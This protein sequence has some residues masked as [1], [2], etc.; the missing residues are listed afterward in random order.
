MKQY[1]I[2]ITN[3]AL[4]DLEEIYTYIAEQLRAPEAAMDQF[5]RIAEAIETLDTYPERV[6]LMES[7]EERT[8]GLRQLIVDYYSVFFH[9]RDERVIITNVLYSASN[10]NLRLLD[11]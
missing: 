9:I 3:R 5:N 11:F 2:Q 1:K 7:E 10:L 6:K 4:S 8:L